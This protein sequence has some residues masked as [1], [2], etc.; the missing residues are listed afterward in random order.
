MSPPAGP[1]TYVLW[2]N[3]THKNWWSDPGLRFNTICCA[4]LFLGVY[5]NGYD[6]SYLN[7]LQAM[8]TWQ[9]FF[10]HPTGSKL[11]LITAVT[12]FPSFVT[13]PFIADL[14]DRFGRRPTIVFGSLII[15]AGAFL[16]GF[17][18]GLG[19]F[20][21]G[22]AVVGFGSNFIVVGSICLCQELTHP[23]LRGVT[24]A[25]LHGIYYV[26]A[27]VSAWLVFGLVGT[28]KKIGNYAWRI[29]AIGQALGPFIIMIAV[30]TFVP[31]SPRW[32][33]SKNRNEEALTILA[34]LH[35]NGDKEDELVVNEFQ[36]IETAIALERQNSTSWASLFATSAN[37]RRMLVLTIIATGTQW[38][39]LGILSFYL[40]PVLKSVGITSSTAQAGF[41]GGIAIWN[42]LCTIIGAMCVDK[43]GRRKMWIGGTS[44]FVV[45]YAGF[46]ACSAEFAKTK[47]PAV[48][49]G[50]IVFVFFVYAGYNFVWNP[51]SYSYSAEILPFSLRAKGIA[52][53][54]FV[55]A[56]SVA[57]NQY[58]NPIALSALAWKYYAVYICTSVSYTI[59]AYFLFPETRG[60]TAEEVGRLFDAKGEDPTAALQ[61][62]VQATHVENGMKDTGSLE[63]KDRA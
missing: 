42:W 22:R 48:G 23:R 52:Y 10:K 32:L 61:A 37:R 31:E 41:N 56:I 30:L 40:S 18:N 21:G 15:I 24:T 29:P 49:N 8:T 54:T 33:I 27:I 62:E 28:Q 11:G 6:G 55:Q 35:A 14:C 20:L 50:A 44:F 13:A 4:I 60:Y 59:L 17:A 47:K 63:H 25:L 2:Q 9:T 7:G 5:V 51:L 36:E 38:L 12:Y 1:P 39:G 53:F 43:V 46:M 45:A 19:M 3:N 58:V 57:F 34:R 16:A 26:G